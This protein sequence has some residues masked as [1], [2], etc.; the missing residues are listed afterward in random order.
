M[1]VYSDASAAAAA[2][3]DDQMVTCEMEAAETLAD[4]SRCSAARG[5]SSCCGELEQQIA[6]ESVIASSSSS[7][8]QEV[9]VQNFC[10][11]TSTTVTSA[12]NNKEAVR[13]EL[14]QKRSTSYQ[15]NSASKL[16]R[17]STEAEKEEKRL[18]RVLANRESARQTI[19]RRQAMHL[20]LT[21]K[22]TDLL[23][24][25]ENLKKEKEVAVEEYNYLK[26]RNEFLKVQIA[27]LKNSESRK[28]QEEAISTQTEI[29]SSCTTSAP[30]FLYNQPSLVPF[31]WPNVF[32]FQCASHSDIMC[33]FQIP[34][35]HSDVPSLV[36]PVP[37]LFP[38]LTHG[39]PFNSQSG[40]NER[41]DKPSPTHHSTSSSSDTF[42][43]EDNQCKGLG[44]D[45]P[46]E[47]LEPTRNPLAGNTYNHNAVSAPEHILQG[48]VKKNKELN[49]HK[50]SE[51]ALAATKARRRRKELLKLKNIRYHH[52]HALTS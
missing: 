17:K 25:N 45:G 4:L 36:L 26:D 52:N 34:M 24:E 43:M 42:L 18:R 21:R 16:R 8:D 10:G 27:K 6:T 2:E 47:D 9:A 29:S 23:E 48:L 33:S 32:Q 39:N 38:F 37:W 46:T 49:M 40:T 14:N 11:N 15:S 19:R 5:G 35:Q 31:F 44:R 1:E 13:T 3:E 30:M 7:Q 28:L 22:A 20:E 12:L 41:H 51:Y 50:I